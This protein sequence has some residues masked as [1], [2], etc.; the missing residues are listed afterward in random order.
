MNALIKYSFEPCLSPA[1]SPSEQH[2]VSFVGKLVRN[3]QTLADYNI[4][5]E[6]SLHVVVYPPRDPYMPLY[7]K[8][9]T[10][11]TIT[12]QV[13]SGNLVEQVKEKIREMEGGQPCHDDAATSNLLA[14][15]C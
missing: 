14:V 6:S 5:T 1:G 10:G 4:Q 2:P 3:G 13:E 7:V 15:Y 11:K 9:L 8:T 12:L